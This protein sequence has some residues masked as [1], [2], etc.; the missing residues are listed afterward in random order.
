MRSSHLAHIRPQPPPLAPQ[1]LAIHHTTPPQHLPR[2]PHHLPRLHFPPLPPPQHLPQSR[3]PRSS[4]FAR[5]TTETAWAD[6]GEGVVL[7]EEG[8]ARGE[9]EERGEV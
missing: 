7:G 4:G 9:G 1:P 6:A 2:L 5:S 3:Y 8:E